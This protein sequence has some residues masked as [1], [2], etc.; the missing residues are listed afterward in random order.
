MIFSNLLETHKLYKNMFSFNYVKFM[1]NN[2][3]ANVL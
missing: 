1:A 3:I 2:N